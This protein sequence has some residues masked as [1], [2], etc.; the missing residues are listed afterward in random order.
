VFTCKRCGH[1]LDITMSFCPSCGAEVPIGRL[2][3]ILGIVCRHCDAY[4]DPGARVCIAC[5]RPLGSITDEEPLHPEPCEG[6]PAETP[7][8][9]P[10]TATAGSMRLVVERGEGRQG[11]AFSL[12]EGENPLGRCQGQ[13]SFPEDPCLAP[14][15]ASFLWRDGVLVV[16]DEG[17]VG[18]VFVRLRNATPLLPDSFFAL[19]ER[20]LRFVGPLPPPPPPPPDGTIRLGSP[21]PD[22]AVLLEEWLEGG[23][24]GR[25]YVR[26][27]PSITIGTS[28]CSI[29]L[30]DDPSLSPVHAELALDAGGNARLR[31]FGSSGGTFVRLPPGTEREIQ[32]GDVLRLGREV[33]R[34]E[35]G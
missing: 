17:A 24:T 3:G 28:G 15:Q 13:L 18:G 9:T 7:A 32:A 26:T 31:D 8:S 16:R 12:T 1:A 2:T 5:E 14:L 30:G 6:V 34:V 29:S 19:G 11:T 20:L 10:P 33:L 22:R 21:R 35:T 23:T 4:N 25:S 27:G